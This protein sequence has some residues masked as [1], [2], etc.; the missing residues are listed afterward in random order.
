[1]YIFPIFWTIVKEDWIYFVVDSCF[2]SINEGFVVAWGLSF[3]PD[4]MLY[5]DSLL[6]RTYDT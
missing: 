6:G 4:V 3:L 5:T 1:M 2:I